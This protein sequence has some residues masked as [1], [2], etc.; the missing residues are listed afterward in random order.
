MIEETVKMI[1]GIDLRQL[2]QA[3]SIVIPIGVRRKAMIEVKDINGLRAKYEEL[4]PGDKFFSDETL[5]DAGEPFSEMF[6]MKHKASAADRNGKEHLCY[7]VA[8]VNHKA[9][10]AKPV[11]VYHYFDVDTLNWVRTN[12]DWDW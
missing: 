4:H 6:L 7:R 8:A 2:I 5:R 10:A 3:R 9:P 12:F 11:D 1:S